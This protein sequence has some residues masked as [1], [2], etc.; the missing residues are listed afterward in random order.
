M[1]A[2]EPATSGADCV[3]VQSALNESAG[4]AGAVS[5]AVSDDDAG[6][7]ASQPL[8]TSASTNSA[9]AN[10]NVNT[11]DQ[12]DDFTT[13]PPRSEGHHESVTQSRVTKSSTARRVILRF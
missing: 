4:G 11:N 1:I 10:A 12:D 2:G 3:T 9:N 13:G 8:V 7:C 6:G 5:A